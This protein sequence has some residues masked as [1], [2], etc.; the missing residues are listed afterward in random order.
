MLGRDAKDMIE[1]DRVEEDRADEDRAEGDRAVS[2]G[3]ELV[4]VSVLLGSPSDPGEGSEDELG[5]GVP[6]ADLV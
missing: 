1:E 6:L 4:G 3:V 5:N 2:N